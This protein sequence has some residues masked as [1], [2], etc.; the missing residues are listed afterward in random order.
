MNEINYQQPI[1]FDLETSGLSVSKHEI[2]EIAAIDPVNKKRFHRLVEFDLSKAD[3]QALEMNHF[4]E[5]KWDEEAR[6]LDE[7]LEDFSTWLKKRSNLPF[8]SKKGNEY[9]LC[10][11]AGYNVLA[12][13]KFFISH[14]YESVKRFFPADYRF[15]DVFPL[16]LWKYPN[17]SSYRLEEICRREGIEVEG[18]HNALDDC[19]ATIKLAQKILKEGIQFEKVEW[20]RQ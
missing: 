17:L 14:A 5:K 1:F 6:P 4:D 13:D 2:I 7:V 11:L 19:R 12:F 20:V 18:F 15:Y 3:P 10:V 16:A 8:T 9:H